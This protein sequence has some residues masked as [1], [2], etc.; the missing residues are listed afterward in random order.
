MKKEGTKNAERVLEA[1][2]LSIMEE[3][4]TII[5]TLETSQGVS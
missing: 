1:L 5:S 4:P 3:T 2:A